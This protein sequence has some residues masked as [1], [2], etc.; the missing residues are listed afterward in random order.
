MCPQRDTIDLFLLRF[1]LL[2]LPTPERR[3]ELLA[4]VRSSWLRQC[5]WV[6][7]QQKKRAIRQQQRTHF[8]G[9]VRHA[10]ESKGLLFKAARDEKRSEELRANY[11]EHMTRKTPPCV[12]I[13][14]GSN[15][16]QFQHQPA[17]G[18][19]QTFPFSSS[20]LPFFSAKKKKKKNPFNE[21]KLKIFVLL[22]DDSSNV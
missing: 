12:C 20:F 5:P 21:L 3:D 2:L 13:Q 22:D 1:E 15:I 8:F 18:G 7:T 9:S 4:V 10:R 11:V 17:D 16:N 19:R 6:Y 14:H